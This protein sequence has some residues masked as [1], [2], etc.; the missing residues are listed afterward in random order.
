MGAESVP[1]PPG[2]RK[3]KKKPDLNRVKDTCRGGE[4]LVNHGMTWHL[5]KVLKCLL[6]FFFCFVFFNWLHKTGIT[7]IIT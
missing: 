5:F 1:P 3:T 7:Y 4:T 6:G 2:S